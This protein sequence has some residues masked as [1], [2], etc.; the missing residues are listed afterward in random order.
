MEKIYRG[1][2]LKS[3]NWIPNSKKNAMDRNQVKE[4][5]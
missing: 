2:K 4:I 3:E 1:S 5:Q